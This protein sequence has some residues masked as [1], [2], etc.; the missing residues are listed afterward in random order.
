MCSSN[1]WKNYFGGKPNKDLVCVLKD[2][3]KLGT[4]FP[5]LQVQHPWM[6]VGGL[7]NL[8]WRKEC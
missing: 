6:E 2:A 1:I 5:A 8:G 7:A 4:L 3:D